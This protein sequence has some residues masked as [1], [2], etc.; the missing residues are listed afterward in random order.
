MITSRGKRNPTKLDMGAGT[1]AGHR[2]SP[3]CPRPTQQSPF[4]GVEDRLDPL[5]DPAEVAVAGRFVASVRALH[6]DSKGGDLPFDLASDEALV[7]QHR[8]AGRRD[9]MMITSASP[10]NRR[11][12]LASPPRLG[13]CSTLRTPRSTC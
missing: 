3:A 9:R 10:R 1:A 7:G 13:E 2:I 6:G 11:L 12:K 8:R 5:P 4:E